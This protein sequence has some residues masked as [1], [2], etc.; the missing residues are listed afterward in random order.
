MFTNSLLIISSVILFLCF[1]IVC[2]LPNYYLR[3]K[4]ESLVNDNQENQ[5]PD[6]KIAFCFM[7][8]DCINNEELWKKFFDS[9]DINKYNIYIHYKHNKKL[10]YFEDKKIKHCIPTAWGDKS[11]VKAS[12]L[13]FKTAFEDDLQNYKF[14]LI[15]NSCIPLKSF[16]FIYDKLTKDNMGYINEAKIQD[17]YKQF[18]LYKKNPDLFAKCG[19]WVILNRKMVEKMAFVDEDFIDITFHG[20]NLIDEIYYHTYIKHHG[21][22]DQVVKT[23]N[24]SSGATTFTIWSD[25]TDYPYLDGKD[26]A[27]PYSYETISREEIDYLLSQPCLFGRKFNVNCKVLTDHNEID[28][29]KYIRL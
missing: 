20:M 6:K 17:Y 2:N 24:L 12:N 21:L 23:P 4:Y 10:K 1:I 13:L 5:R 11:L 7:I 26:K 3:N 15:S 28:L 9:A 16:D 14:T 27:S 25:M 19:Q 22:D 29:H 8:Y 18:Y